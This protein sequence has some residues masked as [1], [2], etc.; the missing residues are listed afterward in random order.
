[1]T[2][3]LV[4]DGQVDRCDHPANPYH[5]PA[6]LRFYFH[7]AMPI[8]LTF[9][10]FAH[11]ETVTISRRLIRFDG[12]PAAGAR[13]R[14]LG[15]Y[16]NF[17]KDTDFEVVA[18]TNG[19]FSMDVTQEDKLWVGHLIIKAEGCAIVCEDSVTGRPK[20]APLTPVIRLGAPFNFAGR[21]TDIKGR[22]IVGA[23]VSLVLARPQS[24]NEIP[25]NSTTTHPITTP[26]LVAHSDTNGDW[27]MSGIDFVDREHPI[28]AAVVFEAVADNP[29]LA[30]KLDLKLAPDSGAPS[31]KNLALDFTLAPLIRVAG[32]V[33]DSV[34]GEP[35]ANVL[36]TRSEIFTSLAGSS[37]LSD[38][39]GTFEL[40]IPG[41]LPILWFHLYRDGYATTS[42]ETAMREQATSDWKNPRQLNI[43]LRPMV[44]VSGRV[45]DQ[46]GKP[47]DEPAQLAADFK[48]EKINS[49]WD[50]KC[51]AGPQPK[52][53]PDGS[54]NAK[55][56]VG[57]VTLTLV[58]PPQ[59]MGSGVRPGLP[60]KHYRLQQEVD[61][62]PHGMTGLQLTATRIQT[63]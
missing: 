48:E 10:L 40:D 6:P 13:V 49:M 26:E 12:K 51:S 1:M 33:V 43:T 15:D 44:A 19:I 25:F 2:R 55:L 5:H 56:P 21:T 47:P 14:V 36:C 11:S 39:A 22:P 4:E 27:S 38:K 46:N 35:V 41:P 60:L 45:L 62:P 50:Q 28:P 58:G 52:V 29:L 57:R 7:A 9:S 3:G 32:R 63:P 31:R 18:D 42:L 8:A 37:T 54:F 16:G 24:A 34:T 30:S 20:S 61:I 23:K 17:N 59:Q 53:G